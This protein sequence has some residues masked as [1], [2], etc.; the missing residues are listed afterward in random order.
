MA[1]PPEPFNGHPNGRPDTGSHEG[2]HVTTTF[3]FWAGMWSGIIVGVL[4][5]GVALIGQGIWEDG[6]YYG[7]LVCEQ[8]HQLRGYGDE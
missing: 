1:K 4:V 5:G 8:Q 2:H 3:G 7:Q 6:R